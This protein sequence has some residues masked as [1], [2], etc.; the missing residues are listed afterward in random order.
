LQNIND[1]ELIKRAQN[2][3]GK[4]TAGAEAVGE[5]YDRYQESVFR[6]IWSR[7]SNPQLAEDLT[8]D[9]FTSMV[10]NLPKYRYTGA[11]FKAWLYSIAR[12]LVIDNYR[13]AS[14]R[15]QLPIEKAADLSTDKDGPAQIV[16]NQ[17]FIEQIQTALQ[18]LTPYK[19]DVLILR[20]IVGLPLQEVASILG[21]TTGSIKITQHR[22]LNKLRMILKS[23]TGEEK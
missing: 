19:Q 12:N 11:P 8:G 3:R 18:E 7:V 2:R 23:N 9:V 6:Y 16:E 1:A 4:P 14:S 17:I 10:V 15:N 5:L 21:K 13:K 22:A 20:F